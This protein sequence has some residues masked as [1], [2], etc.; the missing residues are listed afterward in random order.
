MINYILDSK[1]SFETCKPK[2]VYTRAGVGKPQAQELN[3]TL[4]NKV[5][6]KPAMSRYLQIVMAAFVLQW[7]SKEIIN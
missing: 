5:L 7:E 1:K 6:L 4:V 2:I 3:H